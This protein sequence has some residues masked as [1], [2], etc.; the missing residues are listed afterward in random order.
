MQSPKKKIVFND[1]PALP[2]GM[3]VK[4]LDFHVDNRNNIQDK[5]EQGAY[6]TRLITFNPF[7]CY[8]K[9][10]Y[11]NAGN[12]A[13]GRKTKANQDKLSKAAKKLPELNPHLKR[14]TTKA[15]EGD[16]SRTTFKYLDVGSLP[17]GSGIGD[18]K[19]EQIEKSEEE[20][21]KPNQI[22]NQAIMRINQINMFLISM[23]LPGDFSLH[24]GDAVKVYSPQLAS[25]VEKSAQIKSN[26]Q[27]GGLYI[28]RD[29]C[30]YMT[31]R[32]T[33]TKINVIRDSL[34]PSKGPGG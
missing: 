32:E 13:G 7:N 16:F 14:A 3:D 4:A 33:Y 27:E 21:A 30:H 9:V 22:L 24:A 34:N 23:T 28:I 18:E 8:Y 11:E 15:G 6:S 1:V 19:Q 29:I 12:S 20:I 26:K 5:L 2:A 10:S 25:G 31:P 17:R